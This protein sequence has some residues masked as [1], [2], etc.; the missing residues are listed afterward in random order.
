MARSLPKIGNKEK[1]LIHVAKAQLGLSDDDYRAMLA[2]VGVESSTQLD[3][4]QFEDLMKRFES[5]G[6][7]PKT[8]RPPRMRRQPGD[9]K[10]PLVRKINAILLDEGL[11][12]AYANGIA[13][14]MFGIQSFLW[15]NQEQLWKV[16]AAL[17][18]Y[19]KK[20]QEAGNVCTTNGG[21]KCKKG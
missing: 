15:L 21:G 18:Y 2:S 17:S 14:R 11:T 13:K 9:P 6:F 1:A 19:Q 12:E 5:V 10:T 4:M 8:R 16:V 20:K 3:H 7:K